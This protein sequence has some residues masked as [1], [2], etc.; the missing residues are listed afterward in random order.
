[1]KKDFFAAKLLAE[2][3]DKPAMEGAWEALLASREA[4]FDY[5]DDSEAVAH[6]DSE[7]KE[8]SEAFRKES[9]ERALSELGDLDI[10]KME[11]ARRRGGNPVELTRE[12]TRKFLTRLAFVEERMKED[13]LTW[14][15][16]E[17]GWK[18]NNLEK[19]W[20]ESKEVTP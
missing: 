6:F 13:G 4:G 18:D 3:D 2:L 5:A 7:A 16:I 17:G 10:I 12:G 9:D 8:I 1:M 11:L 19:Y 15:D 14:N 20:K